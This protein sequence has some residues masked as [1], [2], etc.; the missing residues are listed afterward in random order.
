MLRDY[1]PLRG[2]GCAYHEPFRAEEGQQGHLGLLGLTSKI[3]RNSLKLNGLR[4]RRHTAAG[5]TRSHS[6]TYRSFY[7]NLCQIKSTKKFVKRKNNKNK[8]KKKLLF[9]LDFLPNLWYS[10]HMKTDTYTVYHNYSLDAEFSGTR[11]ECEKWIAKV[12][13]KGLGWFFIEKDS[14]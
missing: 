7:E 12:D 3:L 4:G 13:R 6:T 2:A 11:E 14:Q 9:L 1:P 10:Y 8:N 5:V